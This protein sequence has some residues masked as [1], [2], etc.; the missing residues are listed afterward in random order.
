MLVT[1]NF[2][3]AGERNS[4]LRGER[5]SS[6]PLFYWTANI[7]YIFYIEAL[8]IKPQVV[9][10]W[11]RYLKFVQALCC[12]LKRTHAWGGLSK[13]DVWLSEKCAL[14]LDNIWHRPA[15]V[16]ELWLPSENSNDL[17]HLCSQW[18]RW[19]LHLTKD[20]AIKT[21]VISKEVRAQYSHHTGLCGTLWWE[22]QRQLI[23]P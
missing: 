10:D 22:K 9:S 15:R 18:A 8:Y 23:C 11:L 4:R 6:I 1:W 21:A 13:R 3:I 20:G 17:L 16:W 14:I 19:R 12:R 2:T 7:K 5:K